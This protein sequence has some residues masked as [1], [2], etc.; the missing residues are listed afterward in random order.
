[1][2]RVETFDIPQ[3]VR[4]NTLPVDELWSVIQ[5]AGGWRCWTGKDA[6]QTS[7]LTIHRNVE[8]H[9]YPHLVPEFIKMLPQYE[10]DGDTM[11]SAFCSDCSETGHALNWHVDAYEVY[12]FNVEGETIWQYFDLDEG[13]VIDIEMGEMDKVIYMPCG[14][15]HRVRLL[16]ETRTSISLVRPGTLVG[17]P[18]HFART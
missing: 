7:N 10:D 14:Y 9:K 16:S 15:S 12:A 13:K 17:Q 6:D 18:V 1:M 11:I 4:D 5:Q 3:E 2:H 8:V